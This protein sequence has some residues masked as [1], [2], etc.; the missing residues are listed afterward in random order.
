MV[1]TE[2]WAIK[3]K[4]GTLHQD[5]RKDTLRASQ[6]LARPQPLQAKGYEWTPFS[7]KRVC[8]GHPACTGR[9]KKL[10]PQD[11]FHYT[12]LCRSSET[13]GSSFPRFSS[14]CGR[15]WHHS[16]DDG[17]AGMQNVRV[18]GSWKFPPR[19]QKKTWKVRQCMTESEYLQEAP[20]RAMHEAVKIKPK[21]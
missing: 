3:K 9:P 1:V 15:S 8:P 19:C 21:S 10:F 2:I 16:Y 13:S 7:Q 17:F 6:E 5:N 18:L 11:S 12:Q 14:S 4:P 20:E